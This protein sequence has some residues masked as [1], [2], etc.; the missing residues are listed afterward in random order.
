MTM[1]EAGY[2]AVLGGRPNG[3]RRE[4]E[5]MNTPYNSLLDT[6][7][8][9]LSEV[10]AKLSEQIRKTPSKRIVITQNG[11]PSTV[12]LSYKDYLN[13]VRQLPSETSHKQKVIDFDEWK[14][15]FPQRRKVSQSI[16]KL[17]DV[18]TLSRKGQKS[19]K[20]ETVDEFDRLSK[21]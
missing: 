16:S 4:S 19:Y 14:K 9:P 12:L 8:I 17:F 7:F 20:K 2:P 21:K 11:K 15:T 1:T 3:W 18:S 10:K 5:T 6:E 13:L